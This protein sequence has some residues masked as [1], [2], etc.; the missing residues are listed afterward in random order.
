MA[1]AEDRVVEA[2]HEITEGR[3]V[4]GPGMLGCEFQVNNGLRLGSSLS[5]LYFIMVREL[6]TRN[7]STKDVLTEVNT[8]ELA[9]IVNSKQELQEA[10]EG[11]EGGVQEI[12]TEDE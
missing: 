2:M 4:V 6:I 3:V 5:P 8:D 7:L 9:M 10:S 11:V 1:E 12:W